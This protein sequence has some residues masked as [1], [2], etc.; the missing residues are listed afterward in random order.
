VDKKNLYGVHCKYFNEEK[1][2]I[3]GMKI[4][5]KNADE[6]CEKMSLIL[7]LDKQ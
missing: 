3:V 5:E 4:C 1:P 2:E 7:N 6:K